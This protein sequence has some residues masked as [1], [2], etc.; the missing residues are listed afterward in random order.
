MLYSTLLTVKVVI[1]SLLHYW[2]FPF[3]IN[4][5]QTCPARQVL[6]NSPQASSCY[7]GVSVI[8][9]L[10]GVSCCTAGSH[11]GATCVR[12]SCV[13]LLRLGF[14]MS[15]LLV[16]VM[17]SCCCVV[18]GEDVVSLLSGGFSDQTG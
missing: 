12:P 15:M 6:V 16:V 17:M 18:R 7:T 14:M 10:V 4:A 11:S 13:G 1:Y 8:C 9:L 2:T 3:P 5:G